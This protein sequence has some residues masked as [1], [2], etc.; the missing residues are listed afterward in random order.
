M[1]Y[2]IYKAKDDR[3]AVGDE[4]KYIEDYIQLQQI[5]LKRSPDICFSQ[6]ISS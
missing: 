4:V 1:R 2:V 5:R 6:D 3:V